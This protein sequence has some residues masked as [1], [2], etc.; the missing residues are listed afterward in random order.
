MES[1]D[2]FSLRNTYVDSST[3]QSCKHR[4]SWQKRGIAKF[5][6]FGYVLL[7]N[8]LILLSGLMASVSQNL[9]ETI[10]E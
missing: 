1:E 4:R 6:S 10:D 5:E 2:N 8:T 7:R 9:F 3:H